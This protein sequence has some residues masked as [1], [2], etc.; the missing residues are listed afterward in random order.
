[1]RPLSVLTFYQKAFT[2]CVTYLS[3]A[4]NKKF[5]PYPS[6]WNVLHLKGIFCTWG[7]LGDSPLDCFIFTPP[8]GAGMVL[9]GDCTCL[10]PMWTRLDSGIVAIRGSRWLLVQYTLRGLP[11]VSPVFPSN[12]K[13]TFPNSN[14]IRCRISLETTFTWVEL[15]GWI[16]SVVIVLGLIFDPWEWGMSPRLQYLIWWVKCQGPSQFKFCIKHL[17][18]HFHSS[19]VGRR[20]VW[21]VVRTVLGRYALILSKF[22]TC[23][24]SCP[25]DCSVINITLWLLKK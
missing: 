5:V 9:S 16:S 19:T 3:Y 20:A 18:L 8:W 2:L 11:P 10:P 4:C 22:R 24:F 6:L 14:S 7:I 17:Q 12:Q 21:H 23:S 1:M 13:S 25:A 15:P